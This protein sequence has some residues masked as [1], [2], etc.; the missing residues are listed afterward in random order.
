MGWVPS[1][2]GSGRSRTFGCGAACPTKRCLCPHLSF[3][4][5]QC[6]FVISQKPSWHLIIFKQQQQQQPNQTET[7]NITPQTPSLLE[8]MFRASFCFRPREPLSQTVP[9]DRA[10]SETEDVKGLA[11]LEGGAPAPGDQ[12]DVGLKRPLGPQGPS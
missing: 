9:K 6:L 5:L 2:E 10:R 7:R 11:G 8:N 1:I 4:L 3:C 12:V